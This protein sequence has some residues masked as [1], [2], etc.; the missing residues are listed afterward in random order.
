PLKDLQQGLLHTFAAHITRDRNVVRLAADLVDLVDVNDAD[1][2]PLH[3]VIRV[4]EQPQNDVLDIL[5]DISRLGQG[6]GVRNA[7]WHIENAGKRASKERLAAAR[8]TDKQNVAFVDLHLVE[9]GHL[10]RRT[11]V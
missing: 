6:R 8:R 1:L 2:R 4:L 9:R 3:V 7:K 5:T 10:H 11:V